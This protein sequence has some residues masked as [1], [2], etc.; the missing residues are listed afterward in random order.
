MTKT[1]NTISSNLEVSTDRSKLD[2]DMIHRYLKK[3]YWAA[4]RSFEEMRTSIDHSICYGLYLDKK[5]IGFA[6][7]V[8][9]HSVFAYLMDVFIL[10][11]YQ[12]M[13]YG[14]FFMDKV[15]N[16]A[17]MK[18]VEGVRLATKD[19]H[20]FYKKKGFRNISNPEKIMEKIQS[21]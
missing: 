13:G 10:E 12:G 21:N 9:D 14:S 1:R 6:R 7:V 15:L 16:S 3:S 8:S 2:L 11:E 20:N 4:N 17:E 5:Q 18:N 19:A